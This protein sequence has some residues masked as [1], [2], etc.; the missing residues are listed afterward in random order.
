MKKI[1]G[2]ALVA[3]V[4]LLLTSVAHASTSAKGHKPSASCVRALNDAQQ[5]FATQAQ[6][7]TDVKGFFNRVQQSAQ[8]HA[9]GGMIDETVNFLND[10]VTA[11]KTLTSQ[12]NGLTPQVDTIRASYRP[13]RD[14]CLAGR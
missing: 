7:L 10:V 9:G 8:A 2:A 14:A 5:L 12:V 3:V 4:P 6:L 1:I 11:E 13:D